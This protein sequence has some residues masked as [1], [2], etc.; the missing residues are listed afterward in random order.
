[1]LRI[2]DVNF[3]VNSGLLCMAMLV[4]Y[5]V[6]LLLVCLPSTCFVLFGLELLLQLIEG[7]S[8]CW[9]VEAALGTSL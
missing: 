4:R 7:V 9:V 3:K 8:F 6:C 1:M 5:S 2:Q